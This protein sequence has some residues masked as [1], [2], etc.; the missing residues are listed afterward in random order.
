[1][2]NN[3]R[4]KQEDIRTKQLILKELLEIMELW[5]NIPTSQHI[6]CIM[7]PYKDAYYWSEEMLLKKI[8]RYRNE[9]EIDREEV[10]EDRY[11]T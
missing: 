8:E 7:R 6:V 2:V 4:T 9:L 3:K 10:E 1:M 11:G 5:S